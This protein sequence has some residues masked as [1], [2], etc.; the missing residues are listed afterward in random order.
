MK[1][2]CFLINSLPF[3]MSGDF[4]CSASI[5]FCYNDG[6]N[7]AEKFLRF[8][9]RQSTAPFPTTDDVKGAA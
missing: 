7:Y 2:I 3:K 6:K 8:F 5:V 9:G 4:A 1:I